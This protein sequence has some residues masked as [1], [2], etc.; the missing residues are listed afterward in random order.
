M[1]TT[2]KPKKYV[3]LTDPK[4]IIKSGDQYINKKS[5]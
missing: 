1:K 5:L 2:K 4:E 3:Y